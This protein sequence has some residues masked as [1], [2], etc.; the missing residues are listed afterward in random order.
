MKDKKQ[1]FKKV[2]EQVI[3][4]GFEPAEHCLEA[5]EL[6]WKA[7]KEGN[8]S[9]AS[10]RGHLVATIDRMI[11]CH[12]FAKHFFG[13]DKWEHHIQELALSKD[14]IQYLIDFYE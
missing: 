6:W 8:T 5:A 1:K 12:S 3:E 14:R 13:E 2:L 10:Q 9:V 11:M 4:N 7:E